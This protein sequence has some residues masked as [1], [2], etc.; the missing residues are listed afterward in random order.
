MSTDEAL[1]EISAAPAATESAAPSS[2]RTVPR[3]IWT[4]AWRSTGFRVG[5]VV[6]AVL[7]TAALVYPEVSAID[8][9]P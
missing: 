5:L 2:A 8:P 1:V 7:L 6:F 9:T 4:L 3:R